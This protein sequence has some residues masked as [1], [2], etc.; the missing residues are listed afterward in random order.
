[1]L[2]IKGNPKTGLSQANWHFFWWF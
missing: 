1:M 2:Y